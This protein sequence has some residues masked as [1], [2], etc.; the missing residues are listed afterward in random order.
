MNIENLMCATCSFN[1]Y[2]HDDYYLTLQTNHRIPKVFKNIVG[3]PITT[4]IQNRPLKRT[5]HVLK[6]I[7]LDFYN[8]IFPVISVTNDYKFE[9]VAYSYFSGSNMFKTMKNNGIYEDTVPTL[10]TEFEV[11]ML[12]PCVTSVVIRDLQAVDD[13]MVTPFSDKQLEMLIGKGW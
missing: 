3:L 4:T 8:R 11:E 10:L 7:T 6:T 2:C 1:K 9:I 5:E 12:H 13:C